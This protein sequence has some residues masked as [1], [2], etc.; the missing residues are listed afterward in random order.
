MKYYE[1]TNEELKSVIG[2][3]TAETEED[4]VD[5]LLEEVFR[6]LGLIPTEKC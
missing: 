1:L 6:R 4:T 5:A 3:V 2:S